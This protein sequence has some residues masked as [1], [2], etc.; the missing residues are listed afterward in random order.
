MVPEKVGDRVDKNASG[1]V[2]EIYGSGKKVLA[3][4]KIFN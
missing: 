3:G 1:Q 4:K 2:L